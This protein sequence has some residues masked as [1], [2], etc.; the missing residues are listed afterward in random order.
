MIR[1]LKF[2]PHGTNLTLAQYNVVPPFHPG[3]IESAFF[4]SIPQIFF[5]QAQCIFQ[6]GHFIGRHFQFNFVF[7][8]LNLSRPPGQKPSNHLKNFGNGIMSSHET[9]IVKNPETGSRN[10]E[11]R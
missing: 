7:H 8:A 3:S 2:A 9:A 5:E 11:V 10:G 1:T 4:P 6:R